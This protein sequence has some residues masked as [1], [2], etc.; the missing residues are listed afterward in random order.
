MIHELKA[1]SSSLRVIKSAK[2]SKKAT[3]ASA[4]AQYQYCSKLLMPSSI[5]VNYETLG[6]VDIISAALSVSEFQLLN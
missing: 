6:T 4:V 1:T 2:H 5:I 3:S